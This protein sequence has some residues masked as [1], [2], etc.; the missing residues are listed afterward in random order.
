MTY[1]YEVQTY[2]DPKWYQNSVV[3]A[4]EAEAAS[5][6]QAKMWAWT[7]CENTRVV[8]TTEPANYHWDSEKGLVAL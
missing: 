5:A 8:P 4:S 6:A 1:R 7:Q 2:R 3:F